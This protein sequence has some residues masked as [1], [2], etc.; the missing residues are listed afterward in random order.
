MSTAQ[1]PPTVAGSPSSAPP[2]RLGGGYN[3]SDLIWN[4]AAPGH[5]SPRDAARSMLSS[6]D[7]SAC[8]NSHDSASS[9][10]DVDTVIAQRLRELL[11]RRG[12]GGQLEKAS[13]RV[14]TVGCVVFPFV[15]SQRTK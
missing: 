3:G 7:V 4:A 5:Q 6:G 13:G 15:W 2:S 8:R 12:V 10:H 1:A 14:V 9:T 11:G